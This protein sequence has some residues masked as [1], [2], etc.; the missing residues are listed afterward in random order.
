MHPTLPPTCV[1]DN[2]GNKNKKTWNS[3]VQ[4]GAGDAILLGFFSKI[5]KSFDLYKH[6]QKLD[7]TISSNYQYSFMSNTKWKKLFSALDIPELIFDQII[8]KK[9][10][11]D[12]PY[13]T[14]VPQKDDLED[15]WVSEGE[16]EYS[17]FYKEIEWIEIPKIVKPYGYEN[18]PFKHYI[19][20]IELIKNI[21]EEIGK[22]EIEITDIGFKIFGY[23]T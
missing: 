3:I 23:K 1:D 18:I 5:M 10:N 8:L 21:L 13:R 16:N 17:Y 19:Q 22:F 7:K 11:T 6:E 20:D 15:K 2:A 4:N 9:V 12:M 14:W